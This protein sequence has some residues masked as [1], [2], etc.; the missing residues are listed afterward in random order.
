MKTGPAAVALGWMFCGL[1]AGP[2]HTSHKVCFLRHRAPRSGD[3]SHKKLLGNLKEIAVVSRLG[4]GPKPTG[5][6]HGVL[7]SRGA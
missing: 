4:S 2:D 5:Q 1:P 6:G 7:G 3:R